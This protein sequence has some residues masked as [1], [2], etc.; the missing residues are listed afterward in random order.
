MKENL[1]GVNSIWEALNGRRKIEK[2]LIQEGRQGKRIEELLELAQHKGVFI[3]MV[4]K[5]KLDK[6]TGNHQGVIAIV[7]AYPYSTLQE[8]IDLAATRNEPPF[9]V[10]LDGIED[11]RNLGAIIRTADA[12]GAHGVII[13]RHNSVRVNEVVSRASAGAVEYMH[14][15]QETNL[16]NTIKQ[17]KELGVW[18]VGADMDTTNNYFTTTIPAPTVLVIGGEGRGLRRLVKKNCDIL[19]KIPMY[20]NISSLNASVAAALLLYEIRRQRVNLY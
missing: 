15:V 11:P 7:D 16:V 18:V 19:L 10:M 2:I 5:T 4:N 1:A 8:V 6:I 3:Q 9:I 12:A 20:G 17:L 13:P 14:I